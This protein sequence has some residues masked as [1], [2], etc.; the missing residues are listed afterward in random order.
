MVDAL[1]CI[2]MCA[3][4]LT[5]SQLNLPH[6]TKR[7]NINEETKKQNKNKNRGAQKKR[8]FRVK[9][10]HYNIS[11]FFYNNFISFYDGTTPEIKN[12]TVDRWRRFEF[13]A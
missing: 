10:K 3:Q 4:K 12:T 11:N 6:G 13:R 7:K 5:N 2:F 8:W 1:Q 9:I